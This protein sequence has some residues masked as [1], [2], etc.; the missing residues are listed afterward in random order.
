MLDAPKGWKL[1]P[2]EQC[3]HSGWR[4]SGRLIEQALKL[5]A[6]VALVPEPNERDLVIVGPKTSHEL[7]QQLCECGAQTAKW[8]GPNEPLP[9]TS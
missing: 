5:P 7:L 2:I 8:R 9:Y 6:V 1:E 3:S 4:R